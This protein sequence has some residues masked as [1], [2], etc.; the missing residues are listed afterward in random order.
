MQASF[1]LWKLVVKA[2]KRKMVNYQQHDM[3]LKNLRWKKI[4]LTTKK[5]NMQKIFFIEECTV[6]IT[7]T[8]KSRCINSLQIW[9]LGLIYH[10]IGLA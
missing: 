6:I 4:R 1:P 10:L 8:R 7:H 9:D 2:N 3:Q 5:L